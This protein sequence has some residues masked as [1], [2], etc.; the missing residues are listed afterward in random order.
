MYNVKLYGILNTSL[1]WHINCKHSTIISSVDLQNFSYFFTCI[2]FSGRSNLASAVPICAAMRPSPFLPSFFF[3]F[4]F[5]IA[6]R[7][8]GPATFQAS[9]GGAVAGPFALGLARAG[10]RGGVQAP[11]AAPRPPPAAEPRARPRRGHQVGED[12]GPLR[13]GQDAP[14]QPGL[15]DL[16]AGAS[17]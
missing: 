14:A 15:R 10:R 6:G 16:D 8:L 4:F 5:N 11:Q 2:F 17:L 1:N 7:Q 3:F 13:G 9:T 12:D